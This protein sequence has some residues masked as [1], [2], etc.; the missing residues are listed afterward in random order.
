MLDLVAA[1]NDLLQLLLSSAQL[2]S[3]NFVQQREMQLQSEVDMSTVWTSPR[4]GV[5]GAGGII[6]M[7]TARFNESSVRGPI[8]DWIFSVHILEVPLLN[9]AVATSGRPLAGTQISAEEIVQ[10]VLDE[11][12]H[13]AD[14]NLATFEADTSPVVPAS[15]DKIAIGYR[16]NFLLKKG[17]S[18]QTFRTG[19]VQV[20]LG[21]GHFV[22]NCTSDPSASIYYTLDGSFPANSTAINPNTV[23]YNHTSIAATPGQILRARAYL[24]GKIGSATAYGITS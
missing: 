5:A 17:R 8:L 4:N 19:Q 22:L 20:S 2:A 9:F 23:L 10:M 18:I 16:V 3:I 7:P 15:I 14:E 21:G 6:E 11:V 12:H 13:Y 24:S 1:Q